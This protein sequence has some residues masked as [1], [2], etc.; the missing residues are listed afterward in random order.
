MKRA[1]GR[2]LASSCLRGRTRAR[3]SRA[4]GV[5]DLSGA[6]ASPNSDDSDTIDGTHPGGETTN[7]YPRPGL[8]VG[9]RDRWI[10]HERFGEQAVDLYR[11]SGDE[12]VSKERTH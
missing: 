6:T 5:S 12:K 11:R 1:A 9:V 4:H 8:P 3:R 7:G 2:R 10:A